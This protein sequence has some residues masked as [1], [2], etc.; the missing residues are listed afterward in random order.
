MGDVLMS[1]TGDLFGDGVNV[2]S[3]IQNEAEPGQIIVSQDVW[4]QLKQRR[5]F[6]FESIGERTLKGLGAPVW[7]F[8][9]AEPKATED[10]EKA[11]ATTGPTTTPAA[12]RNRFAHVAGIAAA[13]V[14]VSVVMLFASRFLSERFDLAPWVTP[15][16]GALLA[17]G[18]L[19][20]LV[21]A[22]VQ[23]RPTWERS[24]GERGA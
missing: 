23:S 16:A 9:V 15:A 18:L 14:T 3:R 7:L 22:W 19:V 13:Y 21:T 20:I 5:D 24:V 2:A 6:E 4:R 17:I 11:S 12:K 1:P 8:A 10:G